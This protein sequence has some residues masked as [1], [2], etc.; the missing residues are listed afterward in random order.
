MERHLIDRVIDEAKGEG[1]NLVIW[2]RRDTFT[3]ESDDVKEIEIND[4][5]LRVK[6]QDGKAIVYVEY[7]SI[8]KLVVE[9]E[10]ATRTGI[11][12][13]FGAASS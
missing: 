13:G 6:M 8:Y 3:V 9:K 11:R 7:D 1:A 5:H 2:D 10:R 4:D 12:A